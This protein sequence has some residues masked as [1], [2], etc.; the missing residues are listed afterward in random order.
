MICLRFASDLHKVRVC[1]IVY[2]LHDSLRFARSEG[3]RSEAERAPEILA[4]GAERL[5]S[6]R[7]RFSAG[8]EKPTAERP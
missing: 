4:K 1:V 3:R 2:V 5:V 6:K 8:A 7:R